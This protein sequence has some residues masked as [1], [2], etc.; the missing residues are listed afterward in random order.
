MTGWYILTVYRNVFRFQIVDHFLFNRQFAHSGT[1]MLSRM[2][3]LGWPPK[4]FNKLIATTSFLFKMNIL[5]R[6]ISKYIMCTFKW[7]HVPYFTFVTGHSSN[8]NRLN[9]TVALLAAMDFSSAGACSSLSAFWLFWA[10]DAYDL[11]FGLNL[12]I[13]TA[14]TRLSCLEYCSNASTWFL[15]ACILSSLSLFRRLSSFIYIQRSESL[16]I[17]VVDC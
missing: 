7:R 15:S 10:A 17:S 4:F 3:S 5:N 9:V 8:F 16:W 2:K 1:V 13:T 12:L 11:W 6:I 14:V